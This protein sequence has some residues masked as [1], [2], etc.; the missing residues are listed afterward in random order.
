MSNQPVY[1]G[2]DVAKQT[3]DAFLL[4]R[5]C[6]E[7][8]DPEGWSR[9]IAWVVGIDPKAAIACEATGGYERAMIRAF[10]KAGHFTHVLQPVRVRKFAESIGCLAKT[11]KIDAEVIARFAAVRT[12]ISQF[13]VTPTQECLAARVRFQQQIKLKIVDLENQI[14][15]LVE[16]LTKA[17]AAR[18]LKAHQKEVAQI[19]K[20]LAK[21]LNQDVQLQSKVD[22]LT[23]FQGV[24]KITALALVAHLPELGTLGDAKITALAGLAPYNHDSGPIKGKRSISG[25][26]AA[27][28]KA[29]YMASLTASRINP[30]LSVIYK[31][32]RKAG[33]PPKVALTALMRKLL[34]ALNACLRNP[35]FRFVSTKE[36]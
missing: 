28:R 16:P 19:D 26:R 29:L 5:H 8:N 36:I 2:I 35:N 12:P 15:M 34:I 31:R 14:T 3:L 11:D 21:L 1:C 17:S 7:T 33:K 24:G 27:V 25:G 4:G 10:R 20:A 30:V 32:L 13:L 18:L 23:A 9:L 6:H 22:K